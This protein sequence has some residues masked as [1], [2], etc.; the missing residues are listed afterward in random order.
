VLCLDGLKLDGNLFTRDDIGTK[1]DITEAAASDFTTNAVLV[2]DTKILQKDRSVNI[3][4]QRSLEQ[5]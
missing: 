1:V 4:E 2:A 5:L 3:C